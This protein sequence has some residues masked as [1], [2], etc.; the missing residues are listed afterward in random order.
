MASTIKE[1]DGRTYAFGRIPPTRAVPLQVELLKVFGPEIQILLVQDKDKLKG[2]FANVAAATTDEEKQKAIA[3][4]FGIVMEALVPIAF[5]AIQNADGDKV[6]DLM[7]RVFKFVNL[8]GHDLDSQTLIDSDFADCHPG[9]IWKV[10]FE[11]LRV[12]FG[13]FF[14]AAPSA[15]SQPTTG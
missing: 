10:F 14:P 3:D 13:R 8:N 7:G 11:G 4:G 1:I 15:S 6:V 9:T 2:L 12:N 5:G